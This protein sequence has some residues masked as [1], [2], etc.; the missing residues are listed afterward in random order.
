MTTISR[1]VADLFGKLQVQA[2]TEI[3]D[4]DLL[5]MFVQWSHVEKQIR[6]RQQN[7][8]SKKGFLNKS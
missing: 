3:E 6:Q 2:R 5:R 4:R 1:H 7:K 8:I